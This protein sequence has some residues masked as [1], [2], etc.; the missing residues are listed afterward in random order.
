M[1]VNA[2]RDAVFVPK[3]L[4]ERCIEVNKRLYSCFIDF[5]SAFYRV[6]HNI[7]F[8]L[9]SDLESQVRDLKHVQNFCFTQK[10]NI[11]LKD[12]FSNFAEIA[13]GVRQGCVMSP[14]LFFIIL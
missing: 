7:L 2:M 14:D 9:F 4:A 5:T 11:R 10:V 3:N 1:P 8:K 6:H 12:Q 13:R